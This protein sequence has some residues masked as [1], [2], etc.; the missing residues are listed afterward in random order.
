MSFSDMVDRLAGLTQWVRPVDERRDLPGFD[1]PLQDEQV[2]SVG[3]FYGW[4]GLLVRELR[5]CSSFDDGTRGA[6]PTTTSRSIVGLELPG[7]G[8]YASCRR[9]R[10][11]PHVVE[12]EVVPLPT[13]GEIL[14]GVVDDVVSADRA[15]HV[16]VPRAA[17][18][19]DFGAERFGNL[20]GEA[21]EASGRSVDQ[22]FVTWLDLAL[23]AK[24]LEGG[25]CRHPDGRGLLEREVGRLGH[26][27]ALCC[28]GVLGKG[29]RAPA[30]HLIAGSELRDV[31]ADRLDR[32]RDIRSRDTVLWLAHPDRHARDIRHAS[33]ENPVAHM[34]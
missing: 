16:H 28:P 31:L 27:G 2:L 33:D 20:H 4:A 15:D 13:L 24:Q 34:D 25:G 26:E 3:E 11:V 1:E 14:L 12:D 8:E 29:A 7:R 21:A 19:G 6:E 23:I 22:D 18:A 10:M 5:Q 17:H 30:E 32:P 9:Q